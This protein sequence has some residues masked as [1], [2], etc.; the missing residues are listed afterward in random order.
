MSKAIFAALA[1]ILTGQAA[2]PAAAPAVKL[3]RLDCGTVRVNDLNAFS[4]TYTYTGQSRNQVD[5]CYL[6]QHG[7]DWMLWD[8]GFPEQQLGRPL[9]LTARMSST[10]TPSRSA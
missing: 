3:W 2:P 10:L 5:S 7:E 8:T 4:D 6:I 9:N 1:L